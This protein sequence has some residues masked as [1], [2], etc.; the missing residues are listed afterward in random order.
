[1][2]LG[3]RGRRGAFAD[4]G[5]DLT[6]EGDAGIQRCLSWLAR[7]LKAATF[8]S[9]APV[10]VVGFYVS[11]II[12]VL[13]SYG[14]NGWPVCF[15]IWVGAGYLCF[16]GKWT[17]PKGGKT[18]GWSVVEPIKRGSG[19][20]EVVEPRSWPGC[21]STQSLPAREFLNV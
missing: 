9:L 4:S 3:L 14:G 18:G 2:C 21:C 19:T 8:F 10:V 5:A 13:D 20:K 17:D 15:P 7:L 16:S 11:T 6:R 12:D 1:M